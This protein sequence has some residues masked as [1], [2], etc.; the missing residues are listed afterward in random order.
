MQSP[1]AGG[2]DPMEIIVLAII[3]LAAAVGFGGT[4]ILAARQG[5]LERR[6]EALE[7]TMAG[8]SG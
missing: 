8:P 6:M 1:D 2:G 4:L 7:R 3:A 5:R